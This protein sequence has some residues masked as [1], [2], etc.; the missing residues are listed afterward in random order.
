[1]TFSIGVNIS[2][3]R[4]FVEIAPQEVHFT[5]ISLFD[6]FIYFIYFFLFII[7]FCIK[8]LKKIQYI[9]EIKTFG[10]AKQRPTVLVGAVCDYL[11]SL[12]LSIPYLCSFFPS[13]PTR[14]CRKPA[15]TLPIG[16]SN[17]SILSWKQLTW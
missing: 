4:P 3:H 11:D 16:P 13:T 1:M 10:Y 6:L 2:K 15:E 14:N 12:F 17:S 9:R 7:F 8:P 5:I